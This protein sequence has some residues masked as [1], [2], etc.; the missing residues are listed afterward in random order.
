MESVMR[1]KIF[2]LLRKEEKRE[3]ERERERE[4]RIAF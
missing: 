4:E 1:K 2:C 3:R